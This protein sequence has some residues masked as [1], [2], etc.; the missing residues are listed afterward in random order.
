MSLWPSNT[1]VE[2]QAY[3]K[4]TRNPVKDWADLQSDSQPAPWA[5]GGGKPALPCPTLETWDVALPPACFS[6]RLSPEMG[7]VQ[8]WADTSAAWSGAAQRIPPPQGLPRTTL[9]SLFPAPLLPQLH[10]QRLSSKPRESCVYTRISPSPSSLLQHPCRRPSC[11]TSATTHRLPPRA[12]CGGQELYVEH[13]PGVTRSGLCFHPAAQLGLH[14]L[15]PACGQTPLSTP[16]APERTPDRATEVRAGTSARSRRGG[17]GESLLSIPL[18]V[19]WYLYLY[20]CVTLIPRTTCIFSAPFHTNN[21][22]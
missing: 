5:R 9:P 3:K 14:R 10:V 2:T 20:T 11:G 7:S 6:S 4:G 8:K 19:Y 21:G 13:V 17:A 16:S 15:T 12:P 1:E 18:G 22:L